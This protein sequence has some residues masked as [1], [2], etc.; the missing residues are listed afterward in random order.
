[1]GNKSPDFE[2][3]LTGEGD[4]P[5]NIKKLII[6]LL[7]AF[8]TYCLVWNICMWEQPLNAEEPLNAEDA[9]VMCGIKTELDTLIS[10]V[11]ALKNASASKK[12]ISDAIE[13]FNNEVDKFQG[14][15]KHHNI[16]VETPRVDNN[17]KE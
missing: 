4:D 7:G 1:M 5:N 12:E 8:L 6:L 16:H 11:Q 15:V 10:H 3:F 14:L 2:I 17:Y 9:R 13:Q